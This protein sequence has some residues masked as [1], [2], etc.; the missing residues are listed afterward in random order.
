[1]LNENQENQPALL[2]TVSCSDMH[3]HRWRLLYEAW[4]TMKPL[5]EKHSIQRNK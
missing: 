4:R 1:M 2:Q 3:F 5:F